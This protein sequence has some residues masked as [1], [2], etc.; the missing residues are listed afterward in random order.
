MADIEKEICE[1]VEQSIIEALEE[2]DWK[3]ERRLYHGPGL[4]LRLTRADGATAQ[5]TIGYSWQTVSATPGAAALQEAAL[6]EEQREGSG[7]GRPSSS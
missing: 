4:T 1:D 5:V 3:V 6:R 7:K 2:E